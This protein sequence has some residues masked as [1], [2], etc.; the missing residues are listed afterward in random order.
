MM[1]PSTSAGNY[2]YR[3]YLDPKK[4]NAEGFVPKTVGY[5]DKT[6]LGLSLYGGGVASGSVG[7]YAAELADAWANQGLDFMSAAQ[8]VIG[9]TEDEVVQKFCSTVLF[10]SAF[11]LPQARAFVKQSKSE[12]SEKLLMEITL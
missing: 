1:F 2:L 6:V 3:R 9:T 5:L 11:H 10:A 7:M 12:I 8:M 4:V